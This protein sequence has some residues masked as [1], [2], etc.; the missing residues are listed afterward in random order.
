MLPSGKGRGDTF[1]VPLGPVLCALCHPAPNTSDNG[2]AGH[3]AIISSLRTPLDDSPC[4]THSPQRCS[5]PI[6]VAPLLRSRYSGIRADSGPSWANQNLPSG[7]LNIPWKD[8]EALA[9]ELISRLGEGKGKGAASQGGCKVLGTTLSAEE[10]RLVWREL[11]DE[12]LVT[13]ATLLVLRLHET[14]L[15]PFKHSPLCTGSSFQGFLFPANSHSLWARE[16]PP[17]S[18]LGL[19]LCSDPRVSVQ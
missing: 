8:S 2:A 18:A 15:K 7:R 9:A 17:S 6:P 1:S 10:V 11:R 14:L 12:G 3:A 13:P 19:Y 5:S 16:R 4:H